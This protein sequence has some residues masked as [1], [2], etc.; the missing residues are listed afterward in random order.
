MFDSL[1]AGALTLFNTTDQTSFDT[2]GSTFDWNSDTNTATWE[3]SSLALT[4]GTYSVGLSAATI[5][6]SAGIS[7]DGNGDGNAGDDFQ[8]SLDVSTEAV[9]RILGDLDDD[10]DVD[11]TDFQIL[12]AQFGNSG[13]SVG[14]AD[15][16]DD[17]TVGFADFLI[18]SQNFNR[19]VDG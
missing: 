11:F 6:N 5:R 7:L 4:D 9:D 3:L 17:G 19:Q 12:S 10:G 8:L 15:L 16:D 2:T 13:E 14:N 1:T 18:L